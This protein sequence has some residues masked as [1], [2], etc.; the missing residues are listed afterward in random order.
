MSSKI[1][2]QKQN[3]TSLEKNLTRFYNEKLIELF[4]PERNSVFFRGNHLCKESA[5]FKTAN[6]RLAAEQGLLYAPPD[7][8]KKFSRPKTI[9]PGSNHQMQADLIDF[10]VL[11]KKY[12]YNFRFILEIVDVFSRKAFVE[13]KKLKAP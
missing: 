6:T 3:T 8:K 2:N 5:N 4:R 7:N 9:V 11:K 1:K 10:S 12:K 13:F